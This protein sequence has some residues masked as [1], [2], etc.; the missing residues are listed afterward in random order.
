MQII[1]LKLFEWNFC[2]HT[3]FPNDETPRLS[4]VH[5]FCWIFPKLFVCETFKNWMKFSNNHIQNMEQCKQIHRLKH[6]IVN[7][8]TFCFNLI[9]EFSPMIYFEL[10][11]F[12]WKLNF[13][14]IDWNA[15]MYLNRHLNSKHKHGKPI[16][17]QNMHGVQ[18]VSLK[19]AI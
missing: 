17:C 9:I 15:Y 19:L 14:S 3:T 16:Q 12:Q 2:I 7:S 5:S 8:Q 18:F 1:H 10:K 4:F 11:I 6:W 13:D